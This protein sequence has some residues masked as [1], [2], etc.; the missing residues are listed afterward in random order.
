MSLN[1][2][3]AKAATAT[4]VAGAALLTLVGPAAAGPGAPALGDGYDAYCRQYIATTYGP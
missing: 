1:S 4:D 2:R 3:T